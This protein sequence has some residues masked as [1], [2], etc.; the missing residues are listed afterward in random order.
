MRIVCQTR[1]GLSRHD[2]PANDLG[3]T[4]HRSRRVTYWLRSEVLVLNLTLIAAAIC[5]ALAGVSGFGVAW[6]IQAANI[7]QIRLDQANERIAIQRQA[8]ATLERNMSNVATAQAKAADR[9]RRLAADNARAATALDRLRDTS[10]AA[11]RAAAG[12]LEA[13]TRSLASHSVVLSQCSGRLVEVGKDADDWASH[14]IT[15]QDAWPK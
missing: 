5:A 4:C 12:D 7:T 11:L 15:L 13:C 14:G 8:R 2:Y 9:T 3:V 1:E 6:K 10:S